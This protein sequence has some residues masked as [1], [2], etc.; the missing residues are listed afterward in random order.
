MSKDKIDGV[1]VSLRGDHLLL[2]IPGQKDLLRVDLPPINP[3]YSIGTLK[4][5]RNH[6]GGITIMQ[7]SGEGGVFPEEKV[8]AALQAFYAEHF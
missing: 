2:R 8:E 4:I 5:S 3:I 1:G 6:A 7:E